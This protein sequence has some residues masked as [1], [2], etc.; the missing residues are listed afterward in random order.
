[1]LR[2]EG[3][4][5]PALGSHPWVE[6]LGS[7]ELQA[8]GTLAEFQKA[9]LLKWSQEKARVLGVQSFTD[10]V[11]LGKLLNLS[12]WHIITSKM[13]H[14]LCPYLKTCHPS[15]QLYMSLWANQPIPRPYSYKNFASRKI[16]PNKSYLHSA[17]DVRIHGYN[18]DTVTM[19]LLHLE[20]LKLQYPL[21]LFLLLPPSSHHFSQLSGPPIGLLSFLIQ[22][23]LQSSS[24]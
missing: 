9:R 20:K 19:R 10:C 15:G 8:R 7:R 16:E 18:L 4:F 21:P 11:T 17:S 12:E 2:V 22:A 1:M 14:H 5:V 6:E 3:S 24:P 13:D 23:K